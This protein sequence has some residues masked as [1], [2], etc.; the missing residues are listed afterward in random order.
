MQLSFERFL[1]EA[2]VEQTSQGITNRL[3]TKSFAQ[4][5]AGQRKGDLRG[6]ADGQSLMRIT[7]TLRARIISELRCT[8][9]VEMQ[10][11]DCIS[12]RDNRADGYPGEEIDGLYRFGQRHKSNRALDGRL[13]A[14]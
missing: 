10:H 11:A 2:P 1:E 14:I 7:K 9:E 5:Q 3:F 6:R 12:L 4:L 13:R 8:L